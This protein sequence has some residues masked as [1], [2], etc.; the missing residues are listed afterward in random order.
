MVLSARYCFVKQ[1]VKHIAGYHC[2]RVERSVPFVTM[3][4]FFRAQIYEAI[5]ADGFLCGLVL[6]LEQMPLGFGL[7]SSVGPTRAKG[8][9]VYLC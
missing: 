1:V 5:L 9:L 2:T 8:S 6:L 3:N 4:R 7:Y